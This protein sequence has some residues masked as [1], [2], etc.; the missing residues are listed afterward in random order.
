MQTSI[1]T[2]EGYRINAEEG[3]E[4]EGG[5]GMFPKDILIP[6][7]NVDDY[8]AYTP[9]EVID[10]EVGFSSGGWR[11]ER[12]CRRRRWFEIG[13]RKGRRR[14]KEEDEDEEVAN[15]VRP[16][17]SLRRGRSITDLQYSR[18]SLLHGG[19]F[20][21]VYIVCVY[22]CVRSHVHSPSPW[23]EARR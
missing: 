11:V 18:P 22:V 7:A 8:V 6:I 19:S 17:F 9:A 14:G 2:F 1:I 4:K 20:A 21:A 10:Q 23:K 13:G 16:L 12:R 15:R 3:G 5:G